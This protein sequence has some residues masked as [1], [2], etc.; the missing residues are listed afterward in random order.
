M[1]E[2]SRVNREKS[3][4]NHTCQRGGRLPFSQTVTVSSSSSDGNAVITV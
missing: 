2:N 1:Q 4:T 3:F